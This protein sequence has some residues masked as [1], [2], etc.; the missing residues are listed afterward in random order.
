VKASRRVTVSGSPLDGGVDAAWRTVHTIWAGCVAFTT[1]VW[2]LVPV[3]LPVAARA[4]AFGR[5]VTLIFLVVG[6]VEVAV[7]LRFKQ[8]ALDPRMPVRSRQEVLGRLTGQSLVAAVMP[9]SVAVF[10]VAVYVVT[11]SLLALSLLCAL[12]LLGLLLVRP[13][14]E[15][16]REMLHTVRVDDNRRPRR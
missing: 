16:W 11:G 8:R 4:G 6:V 14:L 9:Q 15:E 2:M 3:V 7:G 5:L 1:V 13:R 12:S 10:G